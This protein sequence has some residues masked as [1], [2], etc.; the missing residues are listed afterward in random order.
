MVRSIVCLQPSNNIIGEQI[1]GQRGEDGATCDPDTMK[2][3]DLSAPDLTL[4]LLRCSADHVPPTRAIDLSVVY[5]V[6]HLV[7][8]AFSTR[9]YVSHQHDCIPVCR[10]DRLCQS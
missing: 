10:C 1:L 4:H 2:H 7:Y 5:W 9:A 3:G 8:D 6:W